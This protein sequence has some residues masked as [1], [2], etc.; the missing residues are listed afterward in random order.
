MTGLPKSV[1]DQ[2]AHTP[3][4]SAHPDA[5]VLT[6][7]TENTL[8][9]N[10]RQQVIEHIS[11]CADCREVVFLAQ[12]EALPTQSVLVPKPRRFTRMAWASIAAVVVVVGSAVILEREQITKIEAP[13]SV[14]TT[15]SPAATEAKP[16]APPALREEKA[17]PSPAKTRS[18]ASRRKFELDAAKRQ[19]ETEPLRFSK[20]TAAVPPRGKEQ[21]LA[22]VAPQQAP[23]GPEQRNIAGQLQQ[24]QQPA[25]PVNNVDVAAANE[26]VAKAGSAPAARVANKQRADALQ[27]LATG[28]TAGAASAPL[29]AARAHWKISETGTLERSYVADN[30]TPVLAD[31]GAKFHVVSV[32]GNTIW[33]GGE[34]GA[35]YVSRDGAA[36]WTRIP[37]D[38]TATITSVHF[39]DDLH[40]TLGAADGQVWKTSD[41]GT[42]WQ[43]Q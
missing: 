33:A 26:S 14:A 15:T 42:S 37:I 16:T 19:G 39:S 13:L 23:S 8:T 17:V 20:D 43:K 28:Y 22:R 32:I 29:P 2:M 31:T 9:A 41:S 1:R 35:L 25:N 12:P 11:T 18:E 7:F 10:E 36:T 6:A 38:T 27:G 40:G 21:A 30:W 5:D 24:A 3:A 4:P 34:H